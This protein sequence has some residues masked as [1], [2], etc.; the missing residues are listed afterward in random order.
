[1]LSLAKLRRRH[2]TTDVKSRLAFTRPR[3][4][5]VDLELASVDSATVEV[6]FE[7]NRSEVGRKYSRRVVNI[8]LSS[9]FMKFQGNLIVN[10]WNIRT[11]LTLSYH[12]KSENQESLHLPV[13]V[14]VVTVFR[15]A[16]GTSSL[17][18]AVFLELSVPDFSLVDVNVAEL[19]G[20]YFNLVEI[21][22]HSVAWSPISSPT[23]AN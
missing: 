21:P 2:M 20:A 11:F 17:T 4:L 18:V 8:T 22:G 23:S 9:K 3:C 13:A 14:G 16:T 6:E 1:M 7:L 15:S 12:I 10:F 5:A 19:D